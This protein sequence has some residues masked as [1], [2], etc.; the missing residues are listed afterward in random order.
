MQIMQSGSANIMSDYKPD[1][2]S[3]LSHVI[4]Y[5]WTLSEKKITDLKNFML[6]LRHGKDVC[7][8]VASNLIY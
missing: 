5:F 8:K 3:L 1:P 6:F 2:A 7:T 4:Q